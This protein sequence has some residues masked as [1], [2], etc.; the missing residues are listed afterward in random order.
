MK[1]YTP[2]PDSAIGKICTFFV[3]NPDEELTPDD[4][5]TK[6]GVSQASIHT[7]LRPALETD[8]LSRRQDKEKIY[9]YGLGAKPLPPT[10]PTKSGVNI[11]R[12]QQLQKPLRSQ[13]YSAPRHHLDLDKLVV[14]TDVPYTP[15]R[16]PG[17]DKWAT[18]FQKLG[19][20]GHSVAVPAHVKSAL[21]AAAAKHNKAQG[22]TI[23]KVQK[24]G[25]DSARVWRVA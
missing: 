24:T 25:P 3:T 20:P 2:H 16:Q 19:K 15:G 21:A 1:P 6:F 22:K 17:S 11:D 5:A 8:R 13:S 12:V 7:L 9:F 4:I 10:T 14:E 23:F 18:L